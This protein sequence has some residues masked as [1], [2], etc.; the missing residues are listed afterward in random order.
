VFST[1]AQREANVLLTQAQLTSDKIGIHVLTVTAIVLSVFAE[2]YWYYAVLFLTFPLMYL[3]SGLNAPSPVQRL[4]SYSLS[5]FTFLLIAIGMGHM[6]LLMRIGVST[7]LNDTS[8]GRFAVI[9]LLAVVWIGD[10]GA[11]HVGRK[12]GK[13]I[14]SPMISPKKTW[15]GLGGSIV[16]SLMAAFLF[17]YILNLHVLGWRS[18]FAVGILLPLVGLLGDLTE[19]VFKRAANAK[20]SGNLIP[21]HGGIFDRIDSMLFSAPLLYFL[22][23]FAISN[24]S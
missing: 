7:D 2:P 16:A 12:W 4:E 6:N 5:I 9:Y 22:L 14:L 10:T 18:T 1:L 23:L 3:S 24:Q 20:D 17:R 13:R 19:S 21:G 15:E 11:Y 8:L